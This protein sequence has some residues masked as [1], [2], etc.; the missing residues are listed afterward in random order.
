MS[1]TTIK[2][3]TRGSKLALWQAS[4]VKT[5][6]S[7]AFPD[8]NVETVVI[9]T[10]GDIILDVSLSKIGDKG[11]FTKEIETA[12]LNGEIDLAVH[13]LKDLP[14]ELPEGLCLGG[15]LPRGEVRD[16]FISKDGRKLNE[17]TAN[18]RIATSSLRRKAQVLAYNPKLNIVDIRGNVDTR[19]NKMNDGHCDALLMAGAGIIRLGYDKH[20][21]ELLDPAIVLPAVSQGAVAIE[22]REDDEHIQ[23]I[24]D[25]I[26]DEK[27]WNTTMAERWLLRTLEGGCQ[28][29]V[30]CYSELKNDQLTLTGLVASVDGTKLIRKQISCSIEEA[31]EKAI[32]LAEAILADGGKEILD[33]IRTV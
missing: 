3:G 1:N 13:S 23:R 30:A 2:I 9:K 19:L 4:Q 7:A 28:V 6:I 15:M 33:E 16:V 10:K 31:S 14:T 12:L 17:M 26:S 8:L 29:P 18:D 5:A 11:L 20:I 21:T 25:A 22:I 32:E 24:I 27:T